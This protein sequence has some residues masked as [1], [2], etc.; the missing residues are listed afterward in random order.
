MEKGGTVEWSYPRAAVW[1]VILYSLGL[2][3]FAQLCRALQLVASGSY[4]TTG[5]CIAD[6]FGTNTVQQQL[7][8]SIA[9]PCHEIPGVTPDAHD[10]EFAPELRLH[11]AL[12]ES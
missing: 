8:N 5:G 6:Y 12:S 3:P 2:P 4:Y 9:R 1:F 11:D 7:R 10:C